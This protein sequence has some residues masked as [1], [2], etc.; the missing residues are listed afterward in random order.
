[1]GVGLII[2]GFWIELFV[3]PTVRGLMVNLDVIAMHMLLR[4]HLDV[5]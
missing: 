4:L 2:L 1:M 5:V 3:K